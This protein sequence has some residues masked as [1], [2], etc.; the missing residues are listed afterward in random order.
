[1]DRIEAI[2]YDL[3]D[4]SFVVF[5]ER[6]GTY[7]PPRQIRIKPSQLEAAFDTAFQQRIAESAK[8]T[9]EEV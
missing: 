4:E 6:N 2:T 1:M 3:T 5:L 9:H 8:S 7:G